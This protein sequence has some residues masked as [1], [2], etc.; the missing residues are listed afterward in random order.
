MFK[1]FVSTTLAAAT[2]AAGSFLAV[3]TTA[4]AASGAGAASCP[5][6]SWDATTLGRPAGVAPGMDGAAVWRPS[7]NNVFA[8]R[9]SV[10]AGHKA[11]YTG[12]I[13]ADGALAVVGAHLERGDY[14]KRID[15]HT[16]VFAMTNFGHLDGVDFAPLCSS[17]LKVTLGRNLKLLSTSNIV[18]GST[19]AH[20][21]ANP[22]T[23]TKS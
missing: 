20:P 10:P 21:S 4:V 14:V 8:L 11:L 15:A 23:E 7:N 18:I 3:G 12:A 13:H 2:V 6:G 22:F 9:V 5:A 19:N 16:V 17:R 1:R